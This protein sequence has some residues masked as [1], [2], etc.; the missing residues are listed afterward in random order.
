MTDTTIVRSVR[1]SAANWAYVIERAK[2]R[3]ITPNAWMV[4]MVDMVREGKLAEKKADPADVSA[5][6]VPELEP[7][8]RAAAA[9]G[10]LLKKRKAGR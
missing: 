2:K 1:M 9:P 10:S 3:E 4:K 7:L 5:S 8:H 6:P